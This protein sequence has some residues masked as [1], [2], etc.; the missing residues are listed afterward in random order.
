MARAVIMVTSDAAVTG[1]EKDLMVFVD[2]DGQH[3]GPAT[4]ADP[5]VVQFSAPGLPPATIAI[6]TSLSPEV[7]RWSVGALRPACARVW[8][9]AAAQ[10]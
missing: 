7:G 8:L 6:P 10:A 3:S 2:V 1:P 5:I 4:T 9:G